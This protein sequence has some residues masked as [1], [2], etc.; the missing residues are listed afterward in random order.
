MQF[1]L[2]DTA[3]QALNWSQKLKFQIGEKK[4]QIEYPAP[5]TKATLGANRE[6][7]RAT[8]A[9]TKL[10]SGTSAIHL[11]TFGKLIIYFFTYLLIY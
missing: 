8:A 1:E 9:W 10:R 6:L 11:L 4:F 2:L 5:E 3:T 7:R